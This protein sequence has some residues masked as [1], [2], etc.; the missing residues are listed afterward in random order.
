MYIATYIHV[1]M[2]GC[3]Q[4]RMLS[5]LLHIGDTITG[6]VTLNDFRADNE[7]V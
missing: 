4:L 7:S 3:I 2:N 5:D 6:E 1:N